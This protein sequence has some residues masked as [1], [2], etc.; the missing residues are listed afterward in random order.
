[1]NDIL[2]IGDSLT[3]WNFQNGWGKKMCDWYK[4]KANVVNCGYGGY[5]SQ[6]IKNHMSMITNKYPKPILC[7][8]LLGTNDCYNNNYL[9][10][11]NEYKKNIIQIIQH[12]RNLNNKCIILLITPPVCIFS[13]NVMDYVFKLQE[14]SSEQNVDLINLHYHDPLQILYR[15]LYD[16]IHFNERGNI[17]LFENLKK[18]IL[19]YFD[20][21]SPN[22]ID[23]NIPDSFDWK[24]YISCHPDLCI[25]TNK[26]DA[27]NHWITYGK[28]EGRRL[29]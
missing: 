26:E 29:F 17:K 14:I 25:F 12:I 20:H 22:N 19:E 24:K 18:Y 13:N 28:A 9:T 8:I 21:I 27:W 15:D 23:R 2:L 4:N 16:G 10:P 1:M 5:N 11:P 6:M 3:E 7:T